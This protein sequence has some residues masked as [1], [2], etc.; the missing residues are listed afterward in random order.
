MNNQT[1]TREQLQ[2]KIDRVHAA[3]MRAEQFIDAG[4]NLDSKE[5]VEIGV[6]LV[7]AANGLASEF[8]RSFLKEI[9]E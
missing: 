2:A 5:A 4:K 1:A 3:R 8:G 7:L 9:T 6:E